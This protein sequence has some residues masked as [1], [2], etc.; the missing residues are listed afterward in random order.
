MILEFC[1]LPGAGKSTLEKELVALLAQQEPPLLQRDEAVIGYIRATLWSGYSQASPMRRC[2]TAAY[3]ARLLLASFTPQIMRENPVSFA[4]VHLLR[5]S[6]RLAEDIHLGE[7]FASNLPATNLLNLSEGAIHHLAACHVWQ[8]ILRRRRR[9]NSN[10]ASIMSHHQPHHRVIIHVD[11]PRD[12]ALKRLRCRRIPAKWPIGVSPSA[13]VD[14][15]ARAL[16]HV[17]ARQAHDQTITVLPV[18]GTAAEADWP[19]VA[20]SLADDI[21]AQN[22]ICR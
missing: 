10:G 18:D 15:F 11:V 14:A 19:T 8:H 3:Q 16:P 4:N 5:T 12:V 9:S 1:G 7:W 20:A 22:L 6:M 17:L 21:S 2:A 13:V